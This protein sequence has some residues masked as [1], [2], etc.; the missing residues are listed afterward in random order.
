VTRRIP[1]VATLVVIAAAGVMIRLGIWQ[2]DRMKW[3]KALIAQYE[4]AQ[5]SGAEV[6]WPT[7]PAEVE[8]ALFYRSRLDCVQAMRIDA[9]AGQS[10]DGQPGWSHIAHCRLPNGGT[11]DVALGWSDGPANPPWKGGEV[12]GWVSSGARGARLIASPPQAGLAQ[13][14]RSGPP[15]PTPTG[16]LFYAIQWFAFAAMALVI[17]PLALRRRWRGENSSPNG[18]GGSPQG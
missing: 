1:I 18:G 6:P 8:G 15:D 14:Y 9:I 13:L 4:T 11:A 17:Y 16:H 5:T 2:L 3:K 10:V 7:T 12:T